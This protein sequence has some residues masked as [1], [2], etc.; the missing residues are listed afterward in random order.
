MGARWV[1]RAGTLF[2]GVQE[3]KKGLPTYDLILARF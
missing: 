3:R 1:A 2:A